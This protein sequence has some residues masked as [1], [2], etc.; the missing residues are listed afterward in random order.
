MDSLLLAL[1]V[2]FYLFHLAVAQD[3]VQTFGLSE[4]ILR[5]E[6]E[7]PLG[8]LLDASRVTTTHVA[9]DRLL[10]ILMCIYGAERAG[11]NTLV[12][13]NADLLIQPHDTIGPCQCIDRAYLATRRHSAL[14]TDN[15]HPDNRMRV[16]HLYTQRTLLRVYDTE[17]LHGAN[18]LAGSAS[19]AQ[20]R[21]H[22]KFLGH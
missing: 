20:L 11:L 22:G 16:C 14:A 18:E 3:I 21:Y 9:F 10:T 12:A 2:V 17:A 8:T 4:Y 15:G 6:L 1:F 13:G 7:S 5:Y 19:G